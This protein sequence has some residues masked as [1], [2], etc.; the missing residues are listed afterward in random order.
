ME[1]VGLLSN[2]N[3]AEMQG[4]SDFTR[5]I[6][7]SH[8]L[9]GGSDNN[10]AFN[11]GVTGSVQYYNSGSLYS[12]SGNGSYYAKLNGVFNS[13]NQYQPLVVVHRLDSTQSGNS[14]KVV[15][16]INKE[17]QAISGFTGT[18]AVST[19]GS[20]FR[21]GHAQNRYSWKGDVAEVLLFKRRLKD[22]EIEVIN[23]HLMKKYGLISTCTTP[24]DTTGYD[25]SNCDSRNGALIDSECSITCANGYSA[26]AGFSPRAKCETPD[27]E[28]NFYGCYEDG[29]TIDEDDVASNIIKFF[30]VL[31]LDPSSDA[32]HDDDNWY[33]T[34]WKSQPNKDNKTTTLTKGSTGPVT[35]KR[36][37]G[38]YVKFTGKS[39]E[40]L[41]NTSFSGLLGAEKFSRYSVYTLDGST[42]RL[43][44]FDYG[45]G[46]AGKFTSSDQ[47]QFK[48]QSGGGYAQVDNISNHL[49]TINV[50]GV[51]Y[52][53]S[54]S[55]NAD[56]F[57]LRINGN[58]ITIDSFSGTIAN[59]NSSGNGMRIGANGGNG[60]RYNGEI[61]ETIW[62]DKKLN[63]IE[64]GVIEGYLQR[65]Y[66]VGRTCSLP[67]ST[68]G[69]DVSGCDSSGGAITKDNCTISCADGYEKAKYLHC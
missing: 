31:H 46:G 51:R 17:I 2:S 20:G 55:E 6:V 23:D 28:F 40:Y 53:G 22:A 48:S 12:Y 42:T 21:M 58:D 27:G 9:T 7:L 25:A 44:M 26:H 14:N 52:D 30:N 69:Y 29:T 33:L 24:V 8:D 10:V 41:V 65:K 13:G 1:G 38:T 19:N 60:E 3:F 47:L 61:G 66:G 68:T 59:P 39:T 32:T 18:Q 34:S 54:K 16:N 36:E 15:V 49:N 35:W 45:S 57:D 56:K 50:Q 62:F 43:L 5:V 63:D 4:I 11:D 37:N 67:A 64:N